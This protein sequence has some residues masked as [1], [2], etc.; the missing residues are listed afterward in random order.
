L[1][2]WKQA[3]TWQEG[4]VRFTTWLYRI[5]HNLCI[6]AFRKHK[7]EFESHD[8]LPS[9]DPSQEKSIERQIKHENLKAAMNALPPRQRDAILLCNLQGF[10]N[11]Q[12]AEILQISVDALE[13]LLSRGR[14]SL[15]NQLAIEEPNLVTQSNGVTL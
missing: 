6:D 7:P 15:K 12:A 11:R 10:S 2:V 3:H 8:Q 9:M 5:A 14:R 13:S 1:R 4:R